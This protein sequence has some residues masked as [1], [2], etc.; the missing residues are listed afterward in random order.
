MV[1]F[2]KCMYHFT[3]RKKYQRNLQDS[4]ISKATNLRTKTTTTINQ[5]SS[6]L[7]IWFLLAA[8]DQFIISYPFQ[9]HSVVY[10]P[11]PL[12]AL[13]L[14]VLFFQAKW[15][16]CFHTI[17]GANQSVRK[18][19]HKQ[20]LINYVDDNFSVHFSSNAYPAHLCYHN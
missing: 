12:Q 18:E 7:P 6:I 5:S 10:F 13:L 2:S 8:F 1:K 19:L 20:L 4:N 15:H 16:S 3:Y 14:Y 11:L 9:S 17:K